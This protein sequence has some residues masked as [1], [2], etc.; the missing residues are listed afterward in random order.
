MGAAAKPTT[1]RL[2]QIG[3]NR[4]LRLRSDEMDIDADKSRRAARLVDPGKAGAGTGATAAQALAV[5]RRAA[6]T[7]AGTPAG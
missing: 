2:V 5:A 7:P 6:V 1:I 3:D 4:A